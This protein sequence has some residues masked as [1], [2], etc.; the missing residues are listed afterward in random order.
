MKIYWAPKL[1]HMIFFLPEFSACSI[2]KYDSLL[3]LLVLRTNWTHQTQCKTP[4]WSGA[5]RRRRRCTWAGRTTCTQTCPWK[6][7][8]AWWPDRKKGDWRTV[9]KGLNYFFFSV[10]INVK[11]KKN[12][13]RIFYSRSHWHFVGEDTRLAALSGFS[14]LCDITKD[15]NKPSGTS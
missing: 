8:L 5:R 9:T 11:K 12:C 15:S 7:P 13:F 4:L 14:P 3:L 2:S 10:L 6:D 1:C